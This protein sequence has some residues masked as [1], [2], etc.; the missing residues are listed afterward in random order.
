[1]KSAFALSRSRDQRLMELFKQWDF[2]TDQGNR[3]QHD[4]RSSLCGRVRQ[5]DKD[6][7][8]VLNELSSC[9]V[10]NLLVCHE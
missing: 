10:P 6:L 5:Q 9:C 3:V 1:M 7:S 4:R 2:N 8:F